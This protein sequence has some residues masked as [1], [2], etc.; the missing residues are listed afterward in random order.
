M[1][2]A[3]E[4]FGVKGVD[5]KALVAVRFSLHP[6]F[7]SPRHGVPPGGVQ[8]LRACPHAQPNGPICGCRKAAPLTTSSRERNRAAGLGV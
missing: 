1:A 7:M 3:M 8:G 4:E 2:V 6:P 5:M